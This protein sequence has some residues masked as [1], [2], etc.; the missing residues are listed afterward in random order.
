MKFI[1]FALFTALAACS[2]P[3]T[4]PEARTEAKS[5]K[6][7]HVENLELGKTTKEELISLLGK[8]TK[9]FPYSEKEEIWS[10]L[11]KEGETTAQ[12]LSGSKDWSFNF[13]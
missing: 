9:I 8:P 13:G 10:Y 3:Q 6:L 2:N 1:V 11:E 4:I 12:R 7:V 5:I